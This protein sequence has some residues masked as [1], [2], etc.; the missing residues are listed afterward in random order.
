[1]LPFIAFFEKTWM[2]WWIFAVAVILRWFHT[3]SSTEL[4]A[5][6]DSRPGT[7]QASLPTANFSS[8]PLGHPAFLKN[9]HSEPADGG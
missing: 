5:A 4:L 6:L 2:W 8:L 9:S 1:M 3:Q 7:D